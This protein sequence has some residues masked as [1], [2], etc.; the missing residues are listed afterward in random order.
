MLPCPLSKNNPIQADD[1]WPRPFRD[2]GTGHFPR[3]SISPAE[4][5]AEGGGNKE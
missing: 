5:L 2:E 4:V 3:E 1:K